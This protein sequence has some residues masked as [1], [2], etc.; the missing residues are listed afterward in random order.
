MDAGR[1]HTP[2]HHRFLRRATAVT[3][4]AGMTFAAVLVAAPASAA[5]TLTVCATGCDATTIQAAV[6]AASAGDTITIAAGTYA[7]SVS[8]DKSL[9]LVG[10]NAGTSPNTTDPFTPNAARAAEAVVAP[11]GPIA[12]ALTAAASTV[13]IDGLTID[14]QGGADRQ[15]LRGVGMPADASLTMR[16]NLL[17]GGGYVSE[18]SLV[19]KTTGGDS[20]FTF[21][22]NRVDHDSF[23]NGMFINNSSPAAE[24]ALDIHDNVFIDGSYTAGNFSTANGTV[25]TGTIANNWFGNTTPG[26]AGV[27]AYD[28]RQSGLLFAGSYDG[29][30]VT[31]NTFIDVEDFAIHFWYGFGGEV[32]ITGN[33][34]DGFNSTAGRAAV[35]VN[36]NT[37]Y[38][39]VSDVTFTG[40]AITG[41]TAGSFAV[42]NPAT[43]GVLDARGN[44]W[45]SATPDFDTLVT[46]PD[47]SGDPDFTVMVEGWL[48][49]DPTETDD[50]VVTEDDT[51]PADALADTGASPELAWL[52]ALALLLAGGALTVAARRTARG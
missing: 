44:W 4:A 33:T 3:A 18:G 41:G 19:F 22:G 9:T 42:L 30:Q 34:I 11:T 12:F 10:P 25:I 32:E 27:D 46:V 29:L 16:H 15:Y 14:L 2:A 51:D 47:A 6:T 5:T 28:T 43:T 26:T 52:F 23:S 38:A 50:E 24:L 45:G 7:E 13:E 39:D 48:A 21:V 20:S 35:L 31:G 36:G 8:I 1:A 49:E 37:P 40:N 17:L